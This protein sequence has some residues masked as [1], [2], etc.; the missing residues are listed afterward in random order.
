MVDDELSPRFGA[1]LIDDEKLVPVPT[2]PMADEVVVVVAEDE[3]ENTGAAL[4]RT[5]PNEKLGTP[6]VETPL[7]D[8]RGAKGVSFGA[9]AALLFELLLL[10]LLL[11]ADV[12]KL[13]LL[14]V[15]LKLRVVEL[16]VVVVV[17]GNCCC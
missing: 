4:D 2:P 15:L 6:P 3:K 5:V 14:L 13:I 1:A 16:A 12:P 10:L 9:D 8:V 17:A 7:T 11:L